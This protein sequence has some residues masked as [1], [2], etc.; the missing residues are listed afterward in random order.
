[1]MIPSVLEKLAFGI[2][3]IVLFTQRRLSVG[4]LGLGCVDLLFGALFLA[5][6]GATAP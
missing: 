3:A 5:A 2:P 1:M 6:F 4:D